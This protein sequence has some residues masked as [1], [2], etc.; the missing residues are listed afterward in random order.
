MITVSCKCQYTTNVPDRFAGQSVKC[1][2]CGFG[3]AISASGGVAVMEAT[4][5]P[6]PCVTP[7][8]SPKTEIV[9]DE[10]CL[11]CENPIL[12]KEFVCRSCGWDKK[13]SQRKCVHCF[14]PIV[15]DDGP[16]FGQMQGIA[17]GIGGL[18]LLKFVGILGMLAIICGVAG[19]SGIGT[20]MVMKYRCS[21]CSH[22]VNYDRLTDEE[23]SYE[24]KRRTAF[25]FGSLGLLGLSLASIVAYAILASIVFNS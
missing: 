25:T 21:A 18:I 12:K 20:A 10:L 1:P 22:P 19:V 15:H 9:G 5:L 6:V 23:R 14:M 3:I 13:A 2:R 11:L 17:A 8:P 24:R 16:G 4:P 7:V